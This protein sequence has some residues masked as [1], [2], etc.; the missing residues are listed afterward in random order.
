LRE[1]TSKQFRDVADFLKD[2]PGTLLQPSRL[3][4]DTILKPTP[5]ESASEAAG[6]SGGGAPKVD[7]NGRLR[8]D[9]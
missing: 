4:E 9:I 1:P 5:P 2:D 3:E 8:R 7:S 6:M